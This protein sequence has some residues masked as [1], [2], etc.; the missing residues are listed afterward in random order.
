MKQGVTQIYNFF[1]F[2]KVIDNKNHFISFLMFKLCTFDK[3]KFVPA[4]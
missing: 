4:I 1:L 3:V 2:T